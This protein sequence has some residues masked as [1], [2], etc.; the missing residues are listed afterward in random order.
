MIRERLVSVARQAFRRLGY[1]VHARERVALRE[2]FDKTLVKWTRRDFSLQTTAP[3][4]AL[5]V[6]FSRDRAMQLHALLESWFAQVEGCA[7]LVVLWTASSPAHEKSYLELQDLWGEHVEWVREQSF[8]EDLLQ[9]LNG[10]GSSHLFY[11]TDD[12]VIL[13]PFALADALLES[14]SRQVF[15]LCHAPDLQWCFIAQQAEKV[16][17]LRETGGGLL[18]WN[19]EEGEPRLDWA[20][21]LSLDG[22]FFARAEM[23]VLLAD[24]PFRSPNSLEAALQVFMPLFVG[25]EGVCF[26]KAAMVNVPCNAVQTQYANPVTGAHSTAQLLEFWQRGMRI[27]WEAFIGLAPAEAEQASYRFCQRSGKQVF[28]RKHS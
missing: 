6:W 10:D 20:F 23:E 8:R 11:M 15:S 1:E 9:L 7:R 2:V 14:P 13:R 12:A 28:S 19:W 17:P 3:F 16:P 4:Q 5:G 25:R 24:L 27:E 26:P 21:P 22:K 18:Q